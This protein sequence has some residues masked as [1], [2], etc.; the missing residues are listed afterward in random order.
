MSAL[1]RSGRK[2]DAVHFRA[3]S[4]WGTQEQTESPSVYAVRSGHSKG[5]AM[6]KIASVPVKT[7]LPLTA[8]VLAGVVT[9]FSMLSSLVHIAPASNHIESLSEQATLPAKETH[10]ASVNW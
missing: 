10:Q 4:E 9:L 1:R 3:S 5:I 8:W 2:L 6:I 7:C